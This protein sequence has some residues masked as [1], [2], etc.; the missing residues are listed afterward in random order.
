M[1]ISTQRLATSAALTVAV[2][3][4]V[5]S[6]LLFFMPDKTLNFIGSLHYMK[7]LPFSLE[8]TLMGYLKGV[9]FHSL[10]AYLIIGLWAVVYNKMKYHNA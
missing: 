10:F 9:I 6:L 8:V 3:Y 2:V 5:F 1:K 4:T 7:T